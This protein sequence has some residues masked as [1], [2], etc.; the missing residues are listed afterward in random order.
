[1]SENVNIEN[2]QSNIRFALSSLHNSALIFCTNK[3]YI[4]SYKKKCKDDNIN[5]CYAT[6]TGE[7]QK[8]YKRIIPYLKKE[9]EIP[10]TLQ[11]RFQ[12]VDNF[13]TELFE[14]YYMYPNIN[15]ELIVNLFCEFVSLILK[16][17][18]KVILPRTV[19]DIFI[20]YVDVPI[21]LYVMPISKT[22]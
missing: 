2:M 12:Q 6:T 5:I 7:I 19:Y 1:M 4:L 13:L 20:G 8:Y 14:A 22:I 21:Y 10:E 18:R 17:T 3:Q 15:D 16:I 11:I 9:T